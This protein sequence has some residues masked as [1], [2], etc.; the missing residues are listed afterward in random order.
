MTPLRRELGGVEMF[1]RQ[2]WRWLLAAGCLWAA[3][4]CIPGGGGGG[5]GGDDDDTDG[6]M[7]EDMA[8]D[9]DDGI[10]PDMAIDPDDGIPPPDMGPRA[11]AGCGAERCNGADD[12]CDGEIDEGFDD[13]GAACVAGEGICAA[14]GTVVCS[15]DGAG[16]EC[17]ADIGPTGEEQCND[18]DDD[19]DG[20]VDEDVTLIEC[21]TGERGRCAIGFE[22]CLGGELICSVW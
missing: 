20:V 7:T 10:P 17:L 3:A 19:C 18:L 1:K 22:Q 14:D 5:G 16:T 13:L 4:G 6:G 9:P 8:V 2:R 21:D 11:D 15:P 12:D